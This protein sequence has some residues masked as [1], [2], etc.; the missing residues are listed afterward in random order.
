M[1]PYFDRKDKVYDITEKYPELI[2]VLAGNGFEALR[3]ETMRKTMGRGISLEM[4]LK[5]KKLN[6]ALFEQKLVETI[7]R[8][9]VF[10][11]DSSLAISSPQAVGD[12]RIEGVLPCPIRIPLVEHFENFLKQQKDTLDFTVGYDLKSANLGIDWI[13]P[14]VRSGKEEELSEIFM[15]AG[16]DLFFDRELM[17]QFIEKDVFYVESGAMNKDFANESIDL[18]DPKGQYAISGVVPAIWMVNMDELGDRQ[19]PKTW[20][21]LLKPEFE[22]SISLPIKDLDLFNALLIHIY[23]L[24]GEEGIRKL[25]RSYQKSLHPAQM[26]RSKTVG[27]NVAPAVS[28]APYFFTQMLPKSGPIRAVWPEDGAIISPIFL[29]AKKSKM[30][31]IKPFVDYFMSEEVGTILSAGGKFPSTNPKVD[32]HLS[33][34]QKF[35]WVGWDFI[36]GHDVGA[37]IRR[38]E[39]IFMEGEKQ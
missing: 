2:D 3:N 14:R 33:K 31:K 6:V 16:F 34:D 35:I 30:E 15:S 7:E 18:R 17:G 29:I 23:K 25:S 28:I 38:C 5:S 10:D 27:D 9:R 19:M 24:F 4:A 37:L 36:H 22:N 39:E 21:D 20:A 11:V 26:V 1:N 32:N 12:V 13:V 8:H